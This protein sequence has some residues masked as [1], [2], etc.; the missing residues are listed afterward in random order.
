MYYQHF[1]LCGVPFKFTPPD[2]LFLSAAH[3]AG[4]ATLN[5]GFQQE[6]SG[7]T[8]L[9]GDAGTGK[10][11]LIH[12]L[13]AGQNAG[14]RVARV[15][16][17]TLT[18]DQMLQ[19]ISQ[20]I[21]IHPVGK[22]KLAILQ[23][24]KTFLMDPELVDR[25]MLI[26][27]EAQGLSD[28]ILEEL[29]L[30][31]NIRTNI[32]Q[33]LQIVLVGQP[34]LVQRLSEPKF[35]ALNQRIG[36]R[37]M[38]RPLRGTEIYDYVEHHLREQH[39]NLTIFSRG[40]LERL[41]RL[42]G[43]LPRQINVI[44]HNSLLFAYAEGSAIVKSRHVRAAAAEYKDV[45]AF[46]A[47]RSFQASEAARLALRWLSG[48][49]VPVVAGGIVTIVAL[50]AILPFEI[51]G[52]TKG[53]LVSAESTN[54]ARPQ[55]QILFPKLGQ[56][57]KQSIPV[58]AA[59][60]PSQD[61]PDDQQPRHGISRART[62]SAA[63][64]GSAPASQKPTPPAQSLA[65]SQSKATMGKANGANVSPTNV[66]TKSLETT[67]GTL[68]LLALIPVEE[69]KPSPSKRGLNNYAENAIRYDMNLAEKARRTGR[70]NNA[71]WHLERAVALDPDNQAS[72]DLLSSA[73]RAKAV[74]TTSHVA[75]TSSLEQSAE[76]ITTTAPVAMS[77]SGG[78]DIVKYEIT[79]GDACMR[80]GD[81]DDAL[82]KF[83][84]VRAMD[85]DNGDLD[86]LITNAENAKTTEAKILR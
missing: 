43:G 11:S 41:A 52:G 6:P 22:G 46:S 32:G 55:L 85:P 4:L 26:F 2:R 44:C 23:S 42:S 38:L 66:Q 31:S 86:D 20:E 82:R 79:Q 18:F 67:R 10:T 76:T 19:L 27:D 61:K 47:R 53:R 29:R 49:G 24:L 1:G 75:A 74:S 36:A 34:E 35:R 63:I 25:V 83:K 40:A 9:V 80:K 37:A 64:A 33:S 54:G 60:P 5:W 77:T 81:Y 71:I 28:E 69:T 45:V 58:G 50:G 13:L 14:V 7:L 65:T 73:I 12:T 15:T 59:V 78:M 39:G 17:P 51:A 16:N 8:L 56:A 57:H 68:P 21:G 84:V 72:R 70:Y 30:L 48:R 62:T 3:R